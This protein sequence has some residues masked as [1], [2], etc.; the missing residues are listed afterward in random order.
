MGLVKQDDTVAILSD[1]LGDED[2]A[3]DMDFKVAGTQDGIT[4]LQ[5]D[6]KVKGVDEE[7]LR[8]ALNQAQQGRL[9]ILD[10][11]TTAIGKP[12]PDLSPY[13]PRIIT[14]YIN[15][16][17]I[18]DVIGP[19][20]KIIRNII[21]ETG[22]KMEI[23]DDGR[24]DIAS[25]DEEAARKA[26][27]IVEHLT[28]EAVVGNIYDGKVVRIMDFGAFVEILPGVDGLVHISQLAH[29]RVNKVTDVVKE[30]E[31]IKVKVID[32]DKDGRIKL[33]HKEVMEKQ[34]PRDRRPH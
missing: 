22:V 12:R 19:G 3:G 16:D 7:V 11:M 27:E 33:S 18:R 32:I 2:H 17:K 6:I 9:F 24:V 8:R 23:D 25:V 31:I 34:P 13:A 28:Q 30:G 14:I 29:N 4:A 10:K 1:I 26:V 5:M 21:N 15:P 20:G